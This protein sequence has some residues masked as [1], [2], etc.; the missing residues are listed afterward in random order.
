MLSCGDPGQTVRSKTGRPWRRP[1]VDVF[2][3]RDKTVLRTA[4]M[5]NILLRPHL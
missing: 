5:E 2:G 3:N 1:G 4:A